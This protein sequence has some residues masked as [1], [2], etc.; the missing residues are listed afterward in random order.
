MLGNAGPILEKIANEIASGR[1]PL[2]VATIAIAVVGYRWMGGHITG[3]RA[4]AVIL[5]IGVVGAAATIAGLMVS[6]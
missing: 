3:E 6:G 4:G 2:A 1:I 5:G